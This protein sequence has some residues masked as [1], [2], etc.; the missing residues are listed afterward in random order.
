M[1]CGENRVTLT[2]YA[3][4]MGRLINYGGTTYTGD[5][6]DIDPEIIFRWKQL[7]T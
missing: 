1:K 7:I 6:R 4:I 5:K 3:T 2:V